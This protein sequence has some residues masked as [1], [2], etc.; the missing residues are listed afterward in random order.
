MEQA[1]LQ[2]IAEGIRQLLSE[3]AS[4]QFLIA[5]PDIGLLFSLRDLIAGQQS[6]YQAVDVSAEKDTAPDHKI[7]FIN[8]KNN[9]AMQYQS[10]LY[11][12][13]ELPQKHDCF[14]CL[15]SN[16][17]QCLNYLEKRVR[18]RFT[19]RV[20]FVPYSPHCTETPAAKQ[21]A[22]ETANCLK[23]QSLYPTVKLQK[24]KNTMD[25][26]GLERFSLDFLLGL[27]TPVHLVVIFIG[28]RSP[29][30]RKT[31]YDQ[32]QREVVDLSELKGVKSNKVLGSLYDL[33]DAGVINTRGRSVV[34]YG[35][36]AN[37]I[38]RA[39]PRYLQRLVR[40]H[41]VEQ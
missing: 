13:L 22:D 20:F 4:G 15:I 21:P 30:N 17:A 6:S 5:G 27:C 14:V 33:L 25:K 7:F 31:V 11:Y 37:Y 2:P 16:T 41:C 35:E 18:S 3:G 39:G 10:L 26:Y 9:T 19:N 34:E 12:Y 36:Y 29:V 1:A 23:Q 38:G 28:F 24:M 8:L 40:G 32:F